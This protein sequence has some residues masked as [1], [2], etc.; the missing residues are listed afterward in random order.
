MFGSDVD[1]ALII[2]QPNSP[3]RTVSF[4]SALTFPHY[5]FCDGFWQRV[6]PPVSLSLQDIMF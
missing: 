6:Y 2:L 4:G 3:N 5:H 1:C